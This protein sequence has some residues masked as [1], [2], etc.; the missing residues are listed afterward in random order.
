MNNIA[1]SD[2]MFLLGEANGRPAQVVTLQL[3]RPPDGVDPD[4]WVTDYYH[5]LLTADDLKPCVPTSSGSDCALTV[6]AALGG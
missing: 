6:D 2:A 1:L 3:F 4:E 5:H